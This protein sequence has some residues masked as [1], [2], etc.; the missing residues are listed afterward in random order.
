MKYNRI[1]KNF[2][3]NYNSGNSLERMLAVGETILWKGKPKKNAFVINSILPMM[4]VAIIWL[5]FDSIFVLASF[6]QGIPLGVRIGMWAF[7]ALHLFPFWAWVASII[8]ANKRYKNIEYAITDRRILIKSG[9]VGID[10]QSINYKDINGVHI[11]VG[12]M[13]K[14]LKVGD[15]YIDTP[16]KFKK[17][18][19]AIL[20][21]EDCY[22]VYT[23]L[24]KIILDIQT[25]IEYPNALRPS[26]N[27]GYNT[28]YK[29]KDNF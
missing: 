17:T 24:Q 5:A 29:N 1:E 16:N 13:D 27:P 26:E 25:D 12:L 14:L 10:Y 18:P 11:N 3:N 2:Y 8:T 7:L 19:N 9:F 28:K 20:D 22:D 6:A 21:I 15:I 4:P 23:K